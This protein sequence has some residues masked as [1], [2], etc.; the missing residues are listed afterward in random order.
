M[1]VNVTNMPHV[2]R[3]NLP[4]YLESWLLPE[5]RSFGIAQPSG[6]L[7]FLLPAG[8]SEMRTQRAEV[9]T[10]LM[11]KG[12]ALEVLVNERSHLF[13]RLQQVN[14]CSS[15][16][17]GL[18]ARD[19][20]SAVPGAE[21]KGNEFLACLGSRGQPSGTGMCSVLLLCTHCCSRTFA[22]FLCYILMSW[23]KLL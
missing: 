6:S 19:A 14:K 5:G 1:L 21:S 7:F 4:V 20:D 8:F 3:I 10:Y 12:S 23:S 16:S 18:L 15:R 22:A 9:F 13:T 17:Q 11:S 2:L